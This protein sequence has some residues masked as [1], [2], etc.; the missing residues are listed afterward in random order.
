[1]KLLKRLNGAMRVLR[2]A[3]AIAEA[4]SELLNDLRVPLRQRHRF[5]NH[6]DL[7]NPCWTTNDL[8]RP[9]RQHSLVSS[10]YFLPHSSLLFRAKT[11]PEIFFH[12]FLL[13]CNRVHLH[14]KCPS[15]RVPLHMSAHLQR[16]LWQAQKTLRM[17][18]LSDHQLV[19]EQGTQ[20]TEHLCC[21]CRHQTESLYWRHPPHLH[22]QQ[23]LLRLPQLHI[24]CQCEL[25]MHR[26]F[27][28]R[29]NPQWQR[30]CTTYLLPPLF[31]QDH[32]HLCQPN[33]RACLFLLQMVVLQLRQ[34]RSGSKFGQAA[35]WVS[36]LWHPCRMPRLMFQTVLH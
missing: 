24:P 19:M 30:S 1:M 18:R 13:E 33:F 3:T 14:L 12:L 35:M 29:R 15:H 21:L 7:C 34:M 4:S 32:I 2:P 20:Q 23:V 22:R 31:H 25:L 10:L 26:A 28:K 9:L 5:H 17:L 11:D 6:L 8:H 36:A 27:P 16:S